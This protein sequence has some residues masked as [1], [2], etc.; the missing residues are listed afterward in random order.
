MSYSLS[1]EPRVVLPAVDRTLTFGTD[2]SSCV[3]LAADA[4][5]T[6]SEQEVFVTLGFQFCGN[7]PKAKAEG[8][9]P[10]SPGLSFIAFTNIECS[11]FRKFSAALSTFFGAFCKDVDSSAQLFQVMSAPPLQF[12]RSTPQ[13]RRK[14]TN[15]SKKGESWASR[16][17]CVV[18]CRWDANIWGIFPDLL[19]TNIREKVSS[20][21]VHDIVSNV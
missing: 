12:E 9:S 20:W 18:R 8:T 4:R 14:V 5:S 11:I 16:I 21:V 17:Q 19:R 6:T 2:I 13:K 10:Y 7:L 15:L 3:L 1:V